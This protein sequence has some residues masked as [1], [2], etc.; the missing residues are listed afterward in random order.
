MQ[1][2]QISIRVKN[3]HAARREFTGGEVIEIPG[4][5]RSCPSGHSGCGVVSVIR[6]AARHLVN[7]VGI[8]R[9]RDLAVREEPA[10]GPGDGCSRL[11]RA[12]LFPD[13]NSLPFHQ[14]PFGP[15]DLVPNPP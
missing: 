3:P 1:L 2:A 5:Q 4:D 6:V 13:D 12:P 11:G 10:H 14:E 9:F 8:G 15:H 7:E